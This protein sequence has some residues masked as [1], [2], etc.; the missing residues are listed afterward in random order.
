M[1][2]QGRVKIAV[3]LEFLDKGPFSGSDSHPAEG[4]LAQ[5]LH[6]AVPCFPEQLDLHHQQL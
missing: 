4:P 1:G 5:S 2:I 3:R 6:D